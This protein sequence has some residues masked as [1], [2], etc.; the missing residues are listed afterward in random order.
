VL[1]VCVSILSRTRA[2]LTYFFPGISVTFT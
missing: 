2:G 1:H